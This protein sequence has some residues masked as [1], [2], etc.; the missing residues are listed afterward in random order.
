MTIKQREEFLARIANRLGRP[1]R[2]GVMPP[3]WMV[4]PYVHLHAGLNQETLIKQ[5]IENLRALQTEVLRASR[6]ELGKALERIVEDSAARS[7][8]YWNDER[9]QKIGLDNWLTQR[10][11]AHQV[12]DVLLD[13]QELRHRAAGVD[14]G[15]AYAELGLSE[16]GTVMLWNGGGRGRLVSLLPPVF[17]AVLSENTIIPRLTE[18]MAYVR[19]KMSEGLPACI[20]F[21]TGPSRTGDIEADLAFGVHGPGKV[22][23][24][25]LQEQENIYE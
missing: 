14:M 1:R 6:G 20:N 15:I 18:A 23:V 9:L 11:I 2:S 8:V 17:V 19:G 7:V 21:I 24:I 5:F 13:E 22:Y 3:D 12:W 16:T 4:K 25:L 10:G